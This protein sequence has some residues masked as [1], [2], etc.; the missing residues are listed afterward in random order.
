[1]IPAALLTESN[2]AEDGAVAELSP[3]SIGTVDALARQ[4]SRFGGAVLI[5]DYGDGG[6]SSGPTLQALRRHARHDVL[7]EPGT[8]DMTA[9]VDFRALARAATEAGAAVFGPI[10]QGVWL[11]RL[12]I[13][14]RARRL[15]RDA[16]RRQAQD[17]DR[18]LDR[19]L[20]PEAMGSLFKA[21]AVARRS[22]P[23]PPGFEG[24]P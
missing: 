13:E 21:M 12:G 6:G 14:E 2:R 7:I 10:E 22:D 15:R 16:D 5:V 1:M 20:A 19:L 3:M 17:I 11:R 8:A 9:H 23:T 18:A 4:V 24:D